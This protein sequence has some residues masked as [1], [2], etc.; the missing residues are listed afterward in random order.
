MLAEVKFS[1]NS[2]EEGF[3][4][5][6]AVQNVLGMDPALSQDSLYPAWQAAMV[7]EGGR[8]ANLIRWDKAEER[9]TE[10]GFNPHH[11]LLPIPQVVLNNFPNSIQN[12]GY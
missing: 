9:L 5:L 1:L 4:Y 7:R 3:Q 12:P 10:K 2:L 11:A 8:Y 6:H